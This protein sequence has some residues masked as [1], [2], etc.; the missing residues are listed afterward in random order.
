[1]DTRWW[2]EMHETAKGV[3]ITQDLNS[4]SLCGACY[5]LLYTYWYFTY[6]SPLLHYTQA[7]I[8]PG[9]LSGATHTV[10]AL[11]PG[12]SRKIF[13]SETLESDCQSLFRKYRSRCKSDPRQPA[14]ETHP[15]IPQPTFTHAHH[16]QCTTPLPSMHEASPTSNANLIILLP[17]WHCHFL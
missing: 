6:I 1:M 2:I 14:M 16:H 8:V 15:Q 5:L 3:A 4:G 10:L 12:I 7:S 11:I 13:L 9:Q 17:F